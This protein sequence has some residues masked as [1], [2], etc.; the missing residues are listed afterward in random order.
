MGLY[1]IAGREGEIKYKVVQTKERE[2]LI[3]VAKGAEVH[4]QIYECQYPTLFGL[5]VFDSESIDGILD[6]LIKKV[7]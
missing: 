5:D 1:D 3:T 4:S 6:E 7:S 2:F